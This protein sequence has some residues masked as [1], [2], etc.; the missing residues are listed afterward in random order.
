VLHVTFAGWVATLG[1]IVVLFALD[2]IPEV[3]TST[4][5]L[6]I[7][8]V[9]AVTVTVTV[10]ASLRQARRD[11]DARAH[12]GSLRATGDEPRHGEP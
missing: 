9:L 11:P 6:V 7:V 1:L 5:L 12:A 2:S 10:V 4:S 3:E 8:I